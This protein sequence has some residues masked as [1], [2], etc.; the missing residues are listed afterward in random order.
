MLGYSI[1]LK[2]LLFYEKLL[3]CDEQNV[4]N[5]QK[6]LFHFLGYPIDLL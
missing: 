4:Y 3:R 6:E 1:S 5:S 2:V